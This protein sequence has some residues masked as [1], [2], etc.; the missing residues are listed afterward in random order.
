MKDVTKLNLVRNSVSSR[1][2]SYMIVYY[3]KAAFIF[4][5]VNVI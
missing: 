3:K 5:D 4:V 1:S 2:F